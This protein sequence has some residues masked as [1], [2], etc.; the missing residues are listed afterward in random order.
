MNICFV[1]Q[2]FPGQYKHLAPA[3]AEQQGNQVIG[4]GEQRRLG[5]LRHPKVKEVGYPTP[6]GASK[7]THPYVVGLEASVRRGQATARVALELRKK[8]FVPDMVCCHPGWG[9]GLFLRDVWPEAKSLYFH[10]FYHHGAGHDV[11]FDPEFASSFDDICRVRIRNANLLLS[12]QVADWGITPT[13]W[14]YQALP[15]DIQPRTS[16]IFDGIDTDIVR[17]NK[18]VTVRF[19]SGL[20]LTRKDEV[21]TYVARNL[22]P[23]RGFHIFMRALPE[24]QRRRPNATVVVVGGDEVSYGR[25]PPE[26]IKSYRELYLKELAGKIDLSRVRFVGRV[27]YEQ[28][29]QVLQLSSLHIYL[30]YPWVLSWSML[31]A[32]ST[33]CAIVASRTPP[34]EEVMTNGK[35]GVLTDF[36]DSAAL[37]ETVDRMLDDRKLRERI[38]RAARK[39]VVDRYDL[40]RQCLPAQLELIEKVASGALPPSSDADV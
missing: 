17:P 11:N 8:G 39:F 13:Q 29:L 4:I 2:N 24:I 16:V 35:N 28:Y 21:I 3:L 26:G 12:M 7:T 25:P 36:F 38:G 5:R 19:G 18:D 40:K 27:P 23:Y 33:G 20:T 9:D 10:E 6:R 37:A 22:E 32:M 15:S 14:Q 31:E 30:T 34:V 1:H